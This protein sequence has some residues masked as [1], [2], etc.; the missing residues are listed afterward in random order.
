MEE[1]EEE[2]ARKPP[3]EECEC[4]AGAPAWVVTFGDLMSLLLT[5]FVLLLSFSRMD[6]ERFKEL[7]GSLKEAFGV[8]RIV[9][10]FDL[11]RGIDLVARDFNTSFSA[12]QLE[13]KIKEA[14]KRLKKE[15]EDGEDEKQEGSAGLEGEADTGALGADA[16]MD[17]LAEAIVRAA[18]DDE[19]DQESLASAIE[20]E[21]DATGYTI[22]VDGAAAFTSGQGSLLPEGRLLLRAI[23]PVVLAYGGQILVEGHTDDRPFP[24]RGPGVD[25]GNWQLSYDRAHSVVRYLHQDLGLSLDRLGVVA[26]G[27]SRP[28][29][30]NATAE[31]RG[32]N[33]RVEIVLLKPIAERPH[34]K[35]EVADA[36]RPQK[37]R[38]PKRPPS[39][40]ESGETV[41][42]EANFS[43]LESSRYR[44]SPRGLFPK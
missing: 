43:P 10:A 6:S 13:K 34:A 7:S 27:P 15:V 4:E 21:E 29:A 26:R 44:N 37:P 23:Q 2:T 3:P 5:F 18:L 30:S 24:G 16:A 9:P 33:R 8:Q 31:G 17:A 39:A 42:P 12:E 20:V 25:D 1:G 36:A 41:I 40:K 11:P 19:S 32:M 22:R 14:V 28:R 35:I 38:G